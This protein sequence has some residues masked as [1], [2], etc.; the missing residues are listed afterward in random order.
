MS[1]NI[2]DMIYQLFVIL[3]PIIFI[4]TIVLF[5]RSSK[6]RKNQLKRIEEKLDKV[7]EQK[8]KK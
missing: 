2:G 3:V 6:K 1:L 8:S 4:M 7:S 5:L